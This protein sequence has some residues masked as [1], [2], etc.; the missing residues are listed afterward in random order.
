MSIKLCVEGGG[1]GKILR[2]ACREGFRTFIEKA[3]LAGMMP[4]IVACG[5]RGNAYNDFVVAHQQGSA[6]LLVDAEEPVNEAGSW[7]HLNKRDGWPRPEGA[8]DNQC[9]LMV[10]I[11]E[12]WFLADKDALKEFFGQGYRE[13]AL[14][15]NLRI[16]QIAKGN[17]E[18]GLKDATRNTQKQCYNKG[19]HSFEILAK[20][21]PEKVQN[22]SPHDDINTESD[23]GL[24]PPLDLLHFNW[25]CA[26]RQSNCGLRPPLDQGLFGFD[27]GDDGLL[28][29]RGW[30]DATP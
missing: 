3:G 13:N 21:D 18:K 5:G 7:R 2:T 15:Q 22:A 17:I 24:R 28:G 25:A 12:S 4:R 8:A 9:H 29:F 1:D 16:E 27:F 26:S 14:P 23:C 20:L 30:E 11:V 10:Q 6:M 19:A